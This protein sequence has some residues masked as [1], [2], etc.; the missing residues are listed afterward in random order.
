MS[1]HEQ[2]M[3]A[4]RKAVDRKSVEAEAA[5]HEPHPEHPSG[6]PDVS[7]GAAGE[8]QASLMQAGGSQ[9]E[10]S[11]RAKNTGQGKKTADKWNQ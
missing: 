7:I 3:K 1:D 10:Y 4:F 9:H 2:Q 8:G 11:V 6:G 5:S